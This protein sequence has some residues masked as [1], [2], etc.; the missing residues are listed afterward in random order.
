MNELIN[1]GFDELPELI[2]IFLNATMRTERDQY[3][4]AREYEKCEKRQGYAN[5]YREACLWQSPKR[6]ILG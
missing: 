6:S 1:K 4:Q 5:G 2:R 3:L